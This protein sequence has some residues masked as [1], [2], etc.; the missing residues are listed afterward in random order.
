MQLVDTAASI[1]RTW[2]EDLYDREGDT[3]W[4]VIELDDNTMAYVPLPHGK[5][6]ATLLEDIVALFTQAPVLP[7]DQDTHWVSVS[8]VGTG[9]CEVVATRDEA[10]ARV[11]TMLQAPTAN[12]F[13]VLTTC[14]A[15]GADAVMRVEKVDLTNPPLLGDL[16]VST[17]E[18]DGDIPAYL[19]ALWLLSET[20]TQ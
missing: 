6:V 1:S 10:Q 11:H 17:N 13:H 3:H 7:P 12:T 4:V 9:Y 16:I 18:A 2:V 8:T 15:N 5:P 14:T 19:Q 20:R